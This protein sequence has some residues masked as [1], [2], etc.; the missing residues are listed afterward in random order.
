MAGDGFIL[1]RGG[2]IRLDASWRCERPKLHTEHKI[3]HV[4]TG[5]AEYHLAGGGWFP[6]RYGRIYLLPGRRHHAYRCRG[7]WEVRWWHFGLTDPV[8]D[9]AV[10]ALA[11]PGDWPAERWAAVMPDGAQ[12]DCALAGDHA[13]LLSVGGAT[14][15]IAGAAVTAAGPA[16]TADPRVA[17]AL[18]AIRADPLRPV[19]V[20][21]LAAAS[22][23]G[24]SQFHRLVRAAVGL[25]PLAYRQHLLAQHARELLAGGLAVGRA[26]ERCGFSDPAYFARFVRRQLGRPPRDLARGDGP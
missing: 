10:A 21:A 9:G 8:S 22:G 18:A 13:G 20:A 7:A 26:A 3:Y 4:L 5:T 12:L 19:A 16:S 25:G 2:T 15:A 24:P 17:A 14:L 6:L 1:H 23:V 11:A